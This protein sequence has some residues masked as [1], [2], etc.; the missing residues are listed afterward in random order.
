MS[1]NSSGDVA[2]AGGQQNGGGVS[3]DDSRPQPLHVGHELR[4]DL[5][6]QLCHGRL[7]LGVVQRAVGGAQ[8]APHVLQQGV[9]VPARMTSVC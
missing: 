3:G 9:R 8:P 2:L 6:L 4:E 7:Q 1:P 5:P